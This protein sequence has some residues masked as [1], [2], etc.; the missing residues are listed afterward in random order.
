MDSS[1]SGNNMNKEEYPTARGIDRAWAEVSLD[2]VRSNLEA[3]SA[4]I[5]EKT[6]IINVIKADGYGHGAVPIARA[7]EDLPFLWGHAVAVYEEASQLRRAGARK[8][9]LI[10]GYTFPYCYEAMIR[11]EIRPA[12]FR[13]D[14]LRELSAA[15]KKTG[16]PCH[17]HIAVDTGMNR[18]GILPDD[19]GMAFV[20]T[21]L[22]MPGII[23]EGMFTHFAKADEED[24]AATVRQLELFTAFADRILKETGYKIPYIHCANSAAILAHPNACRLDLVRSG[25]IGYGLM[26]DDRMSPLAGDI[27]PALSLYTRIVYIKDLPA[28]RSVSYGGIFTAPYAMRIATLP[29]GYADGYPR[30]LSSR[31][32]CLIHGKPARIL[33]RVCMDQMMVDVTDIPEAS[34]GDKVVLIGKDG[35]NSIRMEDLAGIC[36]R[37]NYEFACLIGERIP[38]VYIKNG[39]T[40][41][42]LYGIREDL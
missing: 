31:G 14:T 42:I 33:G 19:G 22:S 15:A 29:I 28:G 10:L 41:G 21:A 5:P 26:P 11:E 7:T 1:F 4:R 32:Y 16:R 17:I 40:A 9:I 6:G 8:P 38:R 3:L 37:F 24:P 34:E 39:E 23:V 12:V 36:G 20:K 35:E 13:E 25:I 27:S 18:I 2:A 30:A